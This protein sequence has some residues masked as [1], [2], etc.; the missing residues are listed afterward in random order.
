MRPI[1]ADA[2]KE[3]AI[4]MSTVKEHAFMK[5]VGT[6]EIDK[7]PTLTLDEMRP[8]GRWVMKETMI[9]SP[10]AKNAYCSECLEE[11]NFTHNYCPNC[12]AKMGGGE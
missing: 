6:R 8:K 10:Y 5:A 11:T 3:R 4:K 9:R 2:L 7:A 12:G 1:D